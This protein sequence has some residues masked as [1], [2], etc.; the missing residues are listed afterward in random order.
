MEEEEEEGEEG[1][2]RRQ[3]GAE[4]C[5]GS[6]VAAECMAYGNSLTVENV[7]SYCRECVLLLQRMRSLTNEMHGTRQREHLPAYLPQALVQG[8]WGREH[9]PA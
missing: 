9:L 6:T 8:L 3:G 1:S 5:Q 2:R 7:L 4:I